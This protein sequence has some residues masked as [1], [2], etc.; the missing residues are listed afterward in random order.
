MLIFF[1]LVQETQ[2]RLNN[3]VCMPLVGTAVLTLG[4]T[5][6]M[7]ELGMLSD[8]SWAFSGSMVDSS[9]QEKGV[10]GSAPTVQ[11][12]ISFAP[13]D[14]AALFRMINAEPLCKAKL[15]FLYMNTVHDLWCHL[16]F[17]RSTAVQQV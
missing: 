11:P 10:L 6:A 17:L 2:S 3:D 15:I 5:P 12:E 1:F 14:L 9:R 8:L 16:C 7:R 13:K 4:F